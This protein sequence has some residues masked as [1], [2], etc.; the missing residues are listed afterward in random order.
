MPWEK[1]YNDDEVLT[2]AMQ[3]FWTSGYEAT[4]INDLVATTGIN[5]GSIYSAF[6]D[7]RGLFLKSLEHYDKLY[8]AAFLERVMREHAPREAII[9][10]FEEVAATMHDDEMP[11]GCLLVNTALEVSPHDPEIAA[12]VSRSLEHVGA[13]FADMIDA[14]QAAGTIPKELDGRQAA[15]S[16]LGLFLGLRV[17]CRSKAV[18]AAIT[19]ITA[20]ARAIIS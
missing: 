9:A 11:G 14:G 19:A 16:L 20:Q 13:F 7:K 5:R 8:R 6:K 15:Q 4:S 10:A 1:K 2:R 17:L 3:A 12:F 18:P